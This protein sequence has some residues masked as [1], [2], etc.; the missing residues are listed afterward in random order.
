MKGFI[1]NNPIAS[2][3]KQ[4]IKMNPVTTFVANT[5]CHKCQTYLAPHT[6]DEH[7][8]PTH[9]IHCCELGHKHPPLV[10]LTEMLEKAPLCKLWKILRVEFYGDIEYY[11]PKNERVKWTPR[12]N[13]VTP[14]AERRRILIDEIRQQI[15]RNNRYENLRD[16]CRKIHAM[17]FPFNFIF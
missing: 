15:C 4:V 8:D 1:Y 2:K 17:Y 7:L 16:K 9:P 6:M 10:V 14:L 12:Y 3:Q 5:F 11:T 13:Q